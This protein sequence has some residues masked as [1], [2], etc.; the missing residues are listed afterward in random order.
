MRRSKM[1]MP[2]LAPAAGSTLTRSTKFLLSCDD[3]QPFHLSIKPNAIDNERNRNDERSNCTLKI[4]R[5][6]FDQVDPDAPRSAAEREQRG[7]H[8]ENNMEAFK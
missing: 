1:G 5:F 4:N 7:K 3:A 8:N 6:A 2:S